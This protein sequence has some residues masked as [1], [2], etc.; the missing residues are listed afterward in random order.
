MRAADVEKI[1]RDARVLHESG[2]LEYILDDLDRSITAQLRDTQPDE[3]E[4][5]VALATRLRALDD[6]RGHIQSKL[7]DMMETA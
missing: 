7:L 1:S 5:L 6:L 3:P 2:A 4:K